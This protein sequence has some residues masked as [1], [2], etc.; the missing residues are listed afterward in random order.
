MQARSLLALMLLLP[1]SSFS[2][3]PGVRLIAISVTDG[4][5]LSVLF[6]GLA[7]DASDDLDGAY[8]EVELPPPPPRGVF[9][10]RFVGPPARPF[11]G[12]G[13]IRD[14]RQGDHTTSAACVHVLQCR[15]GRGDTVRVAWDLPADV[16]GRLERQ[17]GGDRVAMDGRGAGCF[18]GASDGLSIRITLHYRPMR[19]RLR[20]LLEGPYLPGMRVM[21]IA[22]NRSGVLDARFAGRPVPARAVDSIGIELRGGCGGEA[23]PFR[24]HVPAWLMDDGSVRDFADTT[25][26]FVLVDSIPAGHSSI[27]LRH[28]NHLAVMT[29]GPV[30]ATAGLVEYD[31]TT[32]QEQ[33]HGIRA[34]KGLGPAGTAPYGLFAGDGDGNGVINASDLITVWSMQNGR[35]GGYSGG[36]YDLNGVV[37]ARDRAMYWRVNNGIAGQV[38]RHIA[39]PARPTVMR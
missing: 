38:P 28:R 16:I 14:L 17:N 11:P 26:S 13:S 31:F 3:T 1:A 21:D 7:F 22:L 25:L 8:G 18:A 30:V 20:A 2:D 5:T 29:A 12:A 4:D 27:V 36:D 39:G 34:M 24:R 35:C 15:S 6:A 33:A 32:A 19:I 37:N 9:D 10:C 23:V